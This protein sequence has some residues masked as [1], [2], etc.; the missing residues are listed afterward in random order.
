MFVQQPS[1]TTPSAL[2]PRLRGAKKP[3]INL[4]FKEPFAGAA[5]WKR[6]REPEEAGASKRVRV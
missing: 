1:A 3:D 4:Y 5:A 2:P 6:S